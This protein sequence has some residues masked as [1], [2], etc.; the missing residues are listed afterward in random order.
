MNKQNT[1]QLS[2]NGLNKTVTKFDD[3]KQTIIDNLTFNIELKQDSVNVILAPNGKGR[4]HLQLI[5]SGLENTYTGKVSWN[6]TSEIKTVY[7]PEQPSSFPWL[8]VK[9]NVELGLVNFNLSKEEKE[10][11]VKK[12]LNL[13]GLEWYDSHFPHNNSYGFRFRISLARALALKP[14]VVFIDNS[15]SLA[16][17]QT[18]QELCSLLFEIAKTNIC[19]IVYTTSSISEAAT[20]S[21]DILILGK[22]P[23]SFAEN[24]KTNGSRDEKRKN[25]AQRIFSVNYGDFDL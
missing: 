8:N 16:D 5:L 24:I 10:T 23:L 2:V 21:D 1:L 7:I 11:E 15:F 14:D 9:E 17:A 18:R 19:R 22:S 25:I 3:V 12:L 4:L 13:C 6:T 20:L